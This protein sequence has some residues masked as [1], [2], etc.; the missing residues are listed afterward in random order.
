MIARLKSQL[1]DWY[2]QLEPPGF[3]RLLSLPLGHQNMQDW[4][5]RDSIRMLSLA[6]AFV[7]NNVLSGDYLEFGIFKGATFMRAWHA[8][9]RSRL[10]AMRFH[11]FDSFEGLPDTVGRDQGPEFRKGQFASPRSTFESRLRAHR[12]DMTRVTITEGW[13]DRTLTPER[14]QEI[15]L[16]KAAIVWIDAD[17][18][19][20]TV[21]I[22]RFLTDVVQDGT[23]I[24][25]DDWHFFKSRQ[26]HGEQLATA[27]W[28]SANPDISLVPYRPFHWGG[29]SFIVHRRERPTA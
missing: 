27:E 12:V 7:A 19:K 4:A 16:S 11:A 21:P 20:S 5:A 29:M 22:L 26:D 9:Q 14:R 23:V 13:F 24:C 3:L 2:L 1:L 6:T 8:A 10:S 18:Y 17:L 25:F 28:L 15:G